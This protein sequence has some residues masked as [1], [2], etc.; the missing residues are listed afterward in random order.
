MNRILPHF[1]KAACELAVIPL[2]SIYQLILSQLSGRLLALP[3]FV[4]LFS[5]VLRRIIT[6]ESRSLHKMAHVGTIS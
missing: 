1:N 3:S 4:L 6:R 5:R 2:M